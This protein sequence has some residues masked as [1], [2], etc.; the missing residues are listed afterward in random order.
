MTQTWLIKIGFG[1]VQRFISEGRKTNDLRV[2]SRIISDLARSVAAAG[3]GLGAT[4]LRPRKLDIENWPHQIVFRMDGDAAQVKTVGAKLCAEMPVQLKKRLAIGDIAARMNEPAVSE[5]MKKVTPAEFDKA[6]QGLAQTLELFWVAVPFDPSQ[7]GNASTASAELIRMYDDRRH[8]RAFIGSAA[9]TDD[10]PW[11]CSLCGVRV[12]VVKPR[13]NGWPE[14]RR[15]NAHERLCPLCFAKRTDDQVNVIRSTH[16]LARDR[17]FRLRRFKDV[18]SEAGED[19]W[20]RMLDQFDDL[21]E[22]AETAD[23]LESRFGKRAVRAFNRL[24]EE[25]IRAIGQLAP[26]YAI[27]LC[28]GDRMGEWFSGSRFRDDIRSDN[29]AFDGAQAELS[30]AL[31]QF[32][33][34]LTGNGNRFHSEVIYAGGDEALILAPLDYVMPW[35]RCMND[36]WQSVADVS[37]DCKPAHGAPMTLSVHASV[38]HAKFPLQPAIRD[39]HRS[40]ED[41]KRA[42]DRNC[43]SLRVCPRGGASADAWLRWDELDRMERVISLFSTWTGADF[44]VEPTME[45]RQDRQK[46][47]APARLIYKTLD[48]IPGFFDPGS[49]KLAVANPFFTRELYRIAAVGGADRRA[50]WEEAAAWLVRR[51][52]QELDSRERGMRGQAQVEGILK[53]A[54]WLARHLD[55]PEGEA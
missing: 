21:A 28:D 54:G 37:S 39:V 46:S 7:P 29:T 5:H 48:A 50:D 14:N 55:W 3:S 51:G 1:G 16:A 52:Q 34:A 19:G 6:C 45:E 10:Q 17:F 26:Y 31:M 4:L 23:K 11:I 33:T 49:G 18:R 8:T 2:G 47:M 9:A 22:G 36:R 42:C 32:A 35:L 43:V 41:A 24:H 53:V 20:R 12:A 15:L 25:H 30:N 13:Q 44:G 38:V 27:L 40:L